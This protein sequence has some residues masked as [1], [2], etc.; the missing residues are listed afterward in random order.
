MNRNMN[1]AV[2]AGAAGLG[3]WLLWSAYRQA[4]RYSFAGKVVLVTGG[5]RG[6]GLVIARRLAREGARLVLC[7]RDP[8]PLDEAAAQIMSQGAEVLAV[9]CD[10]ADADAVRGMVAE[11]IGRFGRLDVVINNAGTIAVGP[12]ETMTEADFRQAM[13]T[14]FWGAVHTVEAAMPYF[15]QQKAGRV[16]NVA[17]IGGLVP[18]PHLVPYT[19][20]KFALVGYT[21][22]LRAELA[23]DGVVVT[24]V[25]PGLMRTGSPRNATFKGHH[26]AEYAWFALSDGNP[27]IAQSAESAAAEVLDASRYS[28]AVRVLSLPAKIMATA[29]ALCPGLYADVQALVNRLLPGPGG[30]GTRG[31]PGRRSQS[32]WTRSPLAAFDD[33]AAKRNNQELVS[34]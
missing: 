18:V 26:R 22:A 14:N 12:V 31:V 25:C 24:L 27:L 28:E 10:V 20:S 16:V 7:G 4:N 3:A 30:V 34:Q 21:Q 29:N 13:D 6:L 11:A 1:A 17:S 33:A 9:P 32:G 19:A 8:V 2:L 23:K 5:S 15:R